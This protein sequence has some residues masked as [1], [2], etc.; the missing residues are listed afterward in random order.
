MAKNK[1]KK[2]AISIN[3]YICPIF[4]VENNLS[5]LQFNFAH[6]IGPILTLRGPAPF[7]YYVSE[8]G[9]YRIVHSN[10]SLWHNLNFTLPSLNNY[11]TFFKIIYMRSSLS[12]L[13]DIIN[14]LSNVKWNLIFYH[15]VI[16]V[17]QCLSMKCIKTLYIKVFSRINSLQSVWCIIRSRLAHY[18]FPFHTL[19]DSV[20]NTPQ[21]DSVTNNTYVSY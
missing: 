5:K 21:T 17:C 6:F 8:Q 10:I 16:H 15:N 9:V 1:K 14:W 18:G 4:H 3:H 19:D 20:I 12:V 11:V 2:I 7:Q 13:I